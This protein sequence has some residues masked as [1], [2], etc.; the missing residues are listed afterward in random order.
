MLQ[1]L[2]DYIGG[3]NEPNV[4]INMTAPVVTKV[5]HG[6]GPFCKSNF[7]VSF[8][9]PFADQVLVG[10]PL[11]CSSPCTLQLYF[12]HTQPTLHLPWSYLCLGAD[13]PFVCR[14]IRHSPPTRMCSSMTH[15]VPP[16]MCLSTVASAWMTSLSPSMCAQL[17]PI[18]GILA[19]QIVRR[20]LPGPLLCRLL[21]MWL[22]IT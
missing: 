10:L 14:M 16:F 22:W 7:T 19:R 1:R 5:E 13:L 15:P 17:L 21:G 6:D 8:F 2:F 12:V 11:F 9:V 20:C 4:K 3:K 18:S